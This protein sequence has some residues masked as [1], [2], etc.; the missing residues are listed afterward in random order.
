MMVGGVGME[1]N[2]DMTV[3]EVIQKNMRVLD[4]LEKYSM[5]CRTCNAVYNETLETAARA[6]NINLEKL[7]YDLRQVFD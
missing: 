5:G 7:I 6:N 2:K 4:V 3:A 1:V